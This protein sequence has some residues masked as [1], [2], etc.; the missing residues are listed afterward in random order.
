MGDEGL[1]SKISDSPISRQESCEV[2]A[3]EQAYLEQDLQKEKLRL[4]NESTSQ[5][6]KERKKYAKKSFKL[7][8]RWVYG[9][10]GMLLLQGFLSEK[11]MIYNTQ[12][13]FKLPDSVLI[14][15]VGGTTASVIGIFLVVANYLFPKK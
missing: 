7:V 9:V 12:F 14:A 5:N 6:I 4:E 1:I 10:F 3:K 2:G 13:Q 11:L 15:V 8:S